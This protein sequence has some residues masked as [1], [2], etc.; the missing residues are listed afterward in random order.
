MYKLKHMHAV[1][2]Q[3]CECHAVQNS[4][5]PLTL[6]TLQAQR[7]A[8]ISMISSMSHNALVFGLV[9]HEP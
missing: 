4:L 2:M 3:C 1:Y 7:A 5:Q 8:E 6:D 9:Q